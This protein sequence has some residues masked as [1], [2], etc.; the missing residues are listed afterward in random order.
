MM[1]MTEEEIVRALEDMER[2]PNFV[3]NAAFTT[4]IAV[5]P[6]NQMP[7]VQHHLHYLK[8]HKLTHP[9]GY[10]SNL[11]LMLRVSDGKASRTT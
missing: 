8:T 6:D 10:L 7:F 4:N 5:W 3:T 1:P 2:D 11:R 9:R